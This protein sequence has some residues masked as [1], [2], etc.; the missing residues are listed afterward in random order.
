MGDEKVTKVLLFNV[1]G[2]SGKILLVGL[3][4]P[5]DYVDG[6]GDGDADALNIE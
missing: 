3:K 5:F 2:S 4:I 6:D 1:F